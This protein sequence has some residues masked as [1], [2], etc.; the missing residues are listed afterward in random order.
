MAYLSVFRK[1]SRTVGLSTVLELLVAFLLLSTL[2]CSDTIEPPHVEDVGPD[3]DLFDGNWDPN[4]RGILLVQPEVIRFEVLEL[5]ATVDSGVQ[6]T[7]GGDYPLVVFDLDALNIPSGAVDISG[8]DMPIGL[9]PG[10]SVDL[11]L[12]YEPTSCDPGE[13]SMRI[14]WSDDDDP[15]K[16]VPIESTGLFAEIFA[17]P[18]FVAFGRLE[19]G[20]LETRE[21]RVENLGHCPLHIDEL[22]LDGGAHFQLVE[23]AGTGAGG[24]PFEREFPIE[25]T[26]DQP[27][28]F[29]VTFQSV[30]DEAEEATLIIGSVQEDDW[31]EIPISAN[32]RECPIAV[33][34]ASR[35]DGTDE[36][37]HVVAAIPLDTI[38]FD[39]SES[40]DPDRELVAYQWSIIDQP[41]DSTAVLEPNETVI[42]P[43]LFLDLAGTYTIELTVFDDDGLASCLPDQVQITATPNEDIHVQLVWHTPG[44]DN[45]TD[46]H[47][48]DLDLHFLRVPGGE[49]DRPPY[50]CHWKNME[51]DWG[52]VGDGDDDPSLDIDDTNGAGPENINLNLPELNMRYAI[53]VHYYSDR[54]MG[55][56][57]ATVRVYINGLPVFESEPTD[58]Q[59][60]GYFWDVGRIEWPSNEVESVDILYPHGFPSEVN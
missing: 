60:T 37:S 44:D 9:L 34:L 51:P 13:S 38:Q 4:G 50:D 29:G 35:I 12:A 15:L 48:T 59:N 26:H 36:P 8:A 21:V 56:S 39:A 58:L 54:D 47:G 43:T 49:W 30:T 27:L 20:Q 3:W 19:L 24:P 57:L 46:S 14:V 25:I 53:G 33:A 31:V 28:L 5:G 6:L 22:Y 1:R 52:N 55:R 32:Q 40:Y 2:A 41:Q 18:E 10:E 16:D 7:N 42:N 17:T 23:L 45:E 11:G